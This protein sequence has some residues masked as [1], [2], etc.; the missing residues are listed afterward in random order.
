MG[1]DVRSGLPLLSL[2]RS[3]LFEPASLAR[4]PSTTARYPLRATGQCLSQ[5]LRSGSLAETGRF[6]Y[7]P[8]LDSL[9]SEVAGTA[10]TVLH[11]SRTPT[12]R[13]SAPP[14]LLAGR[15]L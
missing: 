9:R 1:P 6:P 5:L 8:R 12:S 10:D 15:V 13:G 4:Q 11:R 2:F 7:G 3:P 14:V